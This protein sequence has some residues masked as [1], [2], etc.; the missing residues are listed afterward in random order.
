[1]SSQA[2]GNA[3][4]SIADSRADLRCWGK[5]QSTVSYRPRTRSDLTNIA[6]R[7][8]RAGASRRTVRQSRFI[9]RTV[10]NLKDVCGVAIVAESRL[11][12]QIHCHR[13]EGCRSS[14]QRDAHEGVPIEQT[15]NDAGII[16]VVKVIEASSGAAI[17]T[18]TW[19]HVGV[20]R[21]W[22]GG[23][24]ER[25]GK[26]E[27]KDDDGHRE[28]GTIL[29]SQKMLLASILTHTLPRQVVDPHSSGRT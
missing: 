16:P 3:S 1:M 12:G 8:V 17:R 19:T 25:V 4:I 22:Q 11:N 24:G 29:K 23:A 18:A 5:A 7:T 15:G 14:R 6:G 26:Q 10:G 2:E 27:R 13:G 9:P 28:K 20:L 21:H